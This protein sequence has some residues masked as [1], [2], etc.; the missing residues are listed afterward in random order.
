MADQA[1]LRFRLDRHSGL[2]IYRQL[3]EQV[4]QALHLGILRPGDQLPPVRDVVG[5]VAVNPNTVHR[6]YRELEHQGLVEGQAGRGT[7]V[8]ETLPGADDPHDELRQHLGEWMQRARRA[9]LEDEAIDA[10]VVE[11]KRSTARTERPRSTAGAE[12]ARQMEHTGRTGPTN[13][14]KGEERR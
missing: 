12:D 13:R 1:L 2:P 10:L 5:Q 14:R 6:A 8:R 11:A 3:V 7:F 4:R 9:G